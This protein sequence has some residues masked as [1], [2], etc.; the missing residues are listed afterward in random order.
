MKN[1]RGKRAWNFDIASF[2]FLYTHDYRGILRTNLIS[3]EY[4]PWVIDRYTYRSS[5]ISL[6]R[7]A[8]TQGRGSISDRPRFENRRFHRI[9]LAQLTTRVT[10]GQVCHQFFQSLCLPISFVLL[11]PPPFF[12]RLFFQLLDTQEENSILFFLFF[13]SSRPMH[14]RDNS[15]GFRI[16]VWYIGA[17][18]TMAK[19]CVTGR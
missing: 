3:G 5:I 19:G 16:T 7:L 18:F 9:L 11:P 14:R 4:N 8:E 13:S 12:L 17:I 6:H 10:K 15:E 1:Y 2:F